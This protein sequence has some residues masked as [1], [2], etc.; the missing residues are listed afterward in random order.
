VQVGRLGPTHPDTLTTKNNLASLYM[1]LG[2][3]ELADPLLHEVLQA[4]L[5]QLGPDHPKTL[6]S[7]SN[8]ASLYNRQRHFEKAE[9]LFKQVLESQTA[10]LG[11][12]HPDT[13]GTMSNLAIL[14]QEQ[15]KFEIALPLVQNALAGARRK[16][17]IAHMATQAFLNQLCDCHER[18]GHP[19]LAEPLLRELAEFWKDKTGP[20]SPQY[21]GRLVLIGLNQLRQRKGVEAEASLRECLDIRRKTEP[22]AWSTF[23]TQSMLGEALLLQKKYAEAEP[24]L[25]EGY[26]G[27]TQ[28][29]AMMPP[30]AQ[31]RIPEAVDRLVRLYEGW[32]KTKEAADWRKQRDM[33]K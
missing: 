16:L 23:N 30:P 26:R 4:Q 1:H 17:G 2:K 27:L 19:A 7:K 20:S 14:Y 33:T 18:M 6:I 5:A 31:G 15:G 11:A 29:A 3:W 25:L 12:D 13:L 28:R 22:D 9:Q 24:Q 8:L 32:G 21:A 10:K